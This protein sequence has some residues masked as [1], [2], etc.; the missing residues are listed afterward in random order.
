MTLS[1]MTQKKQ[2]NHNYTRINDT[3][4]QYKDSKHKDPHYA[5]SQHKDIQYRNCQAY[6]QLE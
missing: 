3:H 6:G 4:A 2:F 5:D 1:I